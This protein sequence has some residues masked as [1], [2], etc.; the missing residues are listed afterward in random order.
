MLDVSAGPFILL[1]LLTLVDNTKHKNSMITE[2]LIAIFKIVN[3]LNPVY[4]MSFYSK[5]M[6]MILQSGSILLRSS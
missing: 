4:L 1:P 2:L 5:N 3:Q 6:R